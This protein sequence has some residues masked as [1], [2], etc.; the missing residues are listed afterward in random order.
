MTNSLSRKMGLKIFLL[1]T[2]VVFHCQLSL[3][4]EGFVNHHPWD[5]PDYFIEA[6]Q[7]KFKGEIIFQLNSF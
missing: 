5:D 7:D 1:F 4:F 6:G 3:V 2:A